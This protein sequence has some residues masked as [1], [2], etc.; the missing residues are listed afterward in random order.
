MQIKLL[1]PC[2][3]D[4]VPAEA[5]TVYE[6]DNVGW[7][8]TLINRGWAELV[9]EQDALPTEGGDAPEIL[10]DTSKEEPEPEA[11]AKANARRR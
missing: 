8:K 11:K 6:T 5:G 9:A 10:L 3:V 4:C 1:K 2:L 7:A